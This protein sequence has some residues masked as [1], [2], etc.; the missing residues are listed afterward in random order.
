[1]QA[2]I[3]EQLPKSGWGNCFVFMT[4]HSRTICKAKKPACNAC[5]VTDLGPSC[6]QVG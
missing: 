6:V 4:Y 5:V 2:K 1:M 3:V